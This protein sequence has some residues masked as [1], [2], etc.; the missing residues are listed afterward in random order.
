MR[1]KMLPSLLVLLFLAAVLNAWCASNYKVLHSFTGGNDGEILWGS[2]LL[3]PQGN[4]YGTTNYGGAN[5]GGTVFELSR[6]RN[7]TWSEA[8]LWSF[9]GTDGT[10]STAGL[11]FDKS[12]NLYG[13]TGFGGADANGTVF[14]L[15]PQGDST[16]TETV[17][18]SFGKQ[19]PA[20]PY[21]GV[22]MDASGN[23][24]G[25][26]G[27]YA[28]QLS[29]GSNGWTLTDLHEFLGQDGDGYGPLAGVIL[30]S[31]GNL[32][33]TTEYGGAHGAGTVYEL[34]PGPGGWQERI[35]HSFAASPG[36]GQVPGVGALVSD[37]PGRLYGTT[38]QGG[39]N[40]CVD[41]GCGTIFRLTPGTNGHWKETI[42]YSFSPKGDGAGGFG[43]GGGVVL[44]KAGNIYGTSFYGG[45]P[46]C[47]CGVIY[48]LA[49]GAKGN[50]K[51]TVLHR[52][53]GFDG[54]QPDANLVIDTKGNL[55]GTTTLGGT[56][57]L[58]VAFELTP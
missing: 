19:G 21:A 5:G 23:L 15:S 24:Y 46:H 9:D 12:G 39:A 41:V 44:D 8:T 2:L 38:A 47:G 57:N 43:P 28:Y 4:V 32:Y 56:H 25:T 50:R 34:M 40:I 31:A 26:A 33:G 14:E 55:Y 58:G 30:G 3:G 17:L 54:A 1:S 29:S 37:Q 16:W 49:P 42:L 27:G 20:V 13:T 11:I 36:D 53:T 6:K 52:F 7:G 48:K 18:Y 51:Y 45:D 35:L 10:S 22:T